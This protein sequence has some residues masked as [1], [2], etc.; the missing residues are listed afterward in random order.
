MNIYV[1][2]QRG[3]LIISSHGIGEVSER[4]KLSSREYVGLIM[5]E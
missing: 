1:N 3:D 4:S 2:R 5:G